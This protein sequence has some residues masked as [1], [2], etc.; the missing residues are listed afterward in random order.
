LAT[1]SKRSD[2]GESSGELAALRRQFSTHKSPIDL[3]LTSPGRAGLSHLSLTPLSDPGSLPYRPEP[4]GNRD[5]RRALVLA[6]AN[7][8]ALRAEDLLLTASTSEAY[9]FLLH[10]LCDPGDAILVP[11]P[12]YPL[13]DQLAHLASVEVV[14][15]R[16]A[17]DGAWHIDLS[18]LPDETQIVRQK[19]RAVFSVSPNNPTGNMLRRSEWKALCSLSLPVV[20]DE[21]FRPYLKDG[22]E[23]DPEADPLAEPSAHAPT[24]TLDGLSKR[25]LA[26]GLKA[27]WMSVRGPGSEPLLARLEHIADTFLSVQGPVQ[28]A[29]SSFLE[30]EHQ[31]QEELN[32]RLRENDA[33]LRALTSHTPLTVLHADGAWMRIVRFPKT[34]NEHEWAE[35]L[36]HSG[37]FAHPGEL[38]GL[39]HRPSFV[40]SLILPSTQFEEGVKRM[41]A[42]AELG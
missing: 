14:P 22:Q 40:V 9:S 29:L 35:R 3:S 1:L 11:S 38:Y 27:A 7:R 4:R 34:L 8:A 21:V 26:P 18:S 24:I 36:A 32:Q 5:A 2:F 19:I 30:L 25:A 10:A 31:V 28:H 33:K 20:V 15:Y 13:F 17:Y 23:H 39:P 16:L 6:Y 12:S 41:L 42:L 37:L